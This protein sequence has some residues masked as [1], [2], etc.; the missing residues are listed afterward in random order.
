MPH[1]AAESAERLPGHTDRDLLCWALLAAAALLL[2][3]AAPLL[4][5]RVYTRD[6]LGAFHLPVRAFYAEQLARGEPFDWMP[7]LYSGFYLTGEGQAGTY[8]PLHL[9]LYWSLPLQV[10]LG[11]EWLLS[12]PLMLIGTWLF[13]RR[14]LRRSDAAMFGSLLFTFSAFN[15]LHFIHP[16]A[17]AVVAHIPWL[18][19]A[20]DIV[21]IDAGRLKVALAQAGIA[22]L[23][24]SQLLLGYPQYVWFSLLAEAAYATFVLIDRKHA[25]RDGCQLCATCGECAGCTSSPWSRLVVAKGIGLLLG[26]VQLLPTLDALAQSARQSADASFA[27][28]GSLHPLNLLQLVAPYFFTDRVLGQNTHELGL[29]AGAVPLA[30][31]VWLLAH[32]RSLGSYA[33]LAWFGAG[34]GLCA[35]V[36]AFGKYALLY[37][38]QTWLPLV[39]HF[40]FPCRYVVLFHLAMAVLASIAFVLLVRQNRRSAVVPAAAGGRDARAPGLRLWK[41]FEPLWA[42]LAVSMAVAV[43]GVLLQGRAYIAAVPAVMAG[44]LL[45][46]AAALLIVLAARGARGA[47]IGLVLFAAADLGCYGL[48]YCAGAHSA[49]LEELVAATPTPPGAIDGR[50]L[51]A[52][53]YFDQQGLRTGNQVTLSGWHRADGYAGLEPRRQLDYRNLSALRV[54]GVRWVKRTAATGGIEGLLPHNDRWLEVPDPLPRVRLVTQAVTS[55]DPARD[56]QKICIQSAALSEVPLALPAAAPGT[57]EIAAERPGR[58]A[59]RTECR[60]PQLLVVSESFHRGWRAFVDNSPQPV[61]RINGDFLGCLVAAGEHHVVLEFRPRSLR[62]G[63]LDSCAAVGLLA[64]CVAGSLYRPN[65]HIKKDNMP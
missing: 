53:L 35:L 62:L 30:L 11:C 32:P 33:R 1:C 22:L 23:T 61:L 9:L 16:N 2:V 60:T 26:G 20:I 8:H 55:D 21:V 43:A 59:I 36:L 19:W 41:E 7:Q 58:L 3:L 29:Y 13:L 47:L 50:M 10:A 25:V 52:P 65:L 63:W 56:I 57:A 6:D 15:L 34:L 46:A 42:L 4:A 64:V 51:A 5:G 27:A 48:S 12:Y 17:V 40:R 31:V 14:R 18:L 38:L 39:G 45:V 54:A 49:R 24:G 37:R 44:P 28:S